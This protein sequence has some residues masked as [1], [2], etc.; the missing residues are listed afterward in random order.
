M[1]VFYRQGSCPAM[2]VLYPFIKKEW[3]EKGITP[4]ADA[5]SPTRNIAFIILRKS[6]LNPSKLDGTP[7][8]VLVR[9]EGVRILVS[10]MKKYGSLANVK[11]YII[12]RLFVV[13]D[14]PATMVR[15][16]R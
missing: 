6:G 7:I 13:M 3:S 15:V 12:K 11:S 1:V 4:V 5:G 10:T 2:R 8:H 14:S 9:G 16:M